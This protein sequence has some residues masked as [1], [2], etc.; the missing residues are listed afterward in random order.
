M[1]TVGICEPRAGAAPPV[2]ERVMSLVDSAYPSVLM[3]G[4]GSALV[5]QMIGLNCAAAGF[6]ISSSSATKVQKR[7]AAPGGIMRFM[8]GAVYQTSLSVIREAIVPSIALA[9]RL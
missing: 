8:T 4:I 2:Q 9:V 7:K 3:V 5:L 6:G 1:L